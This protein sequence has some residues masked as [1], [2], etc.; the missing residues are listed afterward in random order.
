[1]F[2]IKGLAVKKTKDR[3]RGVF[4]TR[5]IVAGTVIGDYLGKIIRPE[6]K[7]EQERG[8]Y[9]MWY[10]DIALIEADPKQV[11]IHLI[12]HSCLPNCGIYGLK[13]HRLYFALRRIFSGEELTVDYWEEPQDKTCNPCTHEC[14]CGTEFCRG[15][16][17]L[18]QEKER[19]VDRYIARL[20]KGTSKKVP[21]PYGQ[22]LP[23][24]QQYPDSVADQSIFPL[25]GYRQKPAI[26]FKDIALPSLNFLREQ[27]RS[28]GRRLVFPKLQLQ[29]EGIID[30]RVIVSRLH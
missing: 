2:F 21:V 16:M 22:L 29:V 17:H 13:R 18:T 1:M 7:N 8:L 24:L 19:T 10:S 25:F 6:E 12:N 9:T 26:V 5:D 15:T 4:A 27:I 14:R 30:N 3:G 11:G 28:S 20:D 23:L